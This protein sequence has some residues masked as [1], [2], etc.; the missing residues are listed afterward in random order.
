MVMKPKVFILILNWNGRDY[1]L[2]CL[3]SLR[4]LDYRNCEI[5]VIDNGSTDGSEEAVR[6]LYPDI[7]VLQ[8]RENLGYAEGNNRG[9]QLALKSGTD[10][11]FLLNNDTKIYPECVSRLVEAAERNPNFGILGPVAFDYETG[12]TTLDSGFEI[13]FDLAAK[14]NSS[15]FR[16]ISG[17]FVLSQTREIYEVDFVQGDAFFVKRGVFEKIGLFDPKFFLLNEEADLCVR[18]KNAGFHTGVVKNAS[19]QRMVSP[20]LGRNTPLRGYYA[21]RNTFLFIAKHAKSADKKKT[22]VQMLK[23]MKWDIQGYYLPNFFK[24]WRFTYLKSIA[25]ILRG[26]LDYFLGKFGRI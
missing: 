10:Y 9:I 1:A 19:F 7:K 6:K 13:N 17:D 3:R 21:T 2:A 24:T 26:C 12:R 16:S 4:E 23:K 8:N 11:I 25:F 20:I 18:A 5:A 22:I 15:I 14:A